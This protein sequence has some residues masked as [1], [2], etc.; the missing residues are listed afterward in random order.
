MI[1]DWNTL[2][3]PSAVEDPDD[4]CSTLFADLYQSL[5]KNGLVK[6]L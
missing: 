4:T 5:D 3:T 2:G 6:Q 1:G